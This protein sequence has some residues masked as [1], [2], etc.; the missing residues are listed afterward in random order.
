LGKSETAVYENGKPSKR[1][2]VYEATANGEIL[3]LVAR[4]DDVNDVLKS[5]NRLDKHWRIRVDRDYL[6]V[7]QFRERVGPKSK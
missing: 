3:R 2:A 1:F 7:T 6:T 4:Y 5:T